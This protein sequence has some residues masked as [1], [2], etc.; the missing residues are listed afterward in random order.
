MAKQEADPNKPI[1]VT[2]TY[3]A[4]PVTVHFVDTDENADKDSDAVK[5]ELGK[6]IQLS[7]TYG[8]EVDLNNVKLPANFVID[9]TLPSVQYGKTDSVTINLKH[10]INDVKAENAEDATRT[11]VI[12]KYDGN[13][14]L[15]STQTVVQQIAFYKHDY[16][17]AVTGKTKSSK[18]IFDDK[19]SPALSHNVIDGKATNDPSYTLKDGKYYFAK[20]KLD[21][22]AG[23]K[24]EEKKINPNMMMI[25][26]FALPTTL[27][28]PNTSQT[29]TNKKPD[30]SS[31]SV[32]DKANNSHDLHDDSKKQNDQ[33][34]TSNKENDHTIN[35][36]AQAVDPTVEP[37][38]NNVASQNNSTTS[39]QTQQS[40]TNDAEQPENISNA[41]RVVNDQTDDDNFVDPSHKENNANKG[42]NGS[43]NRSKPGSGKIIHVNSK[44]P[45]N[46]LNEPVKGQTVVTHPVQSSVI[47]NSKS[48]AKQ[49]PQTNEADGFNYT[50]L[51]LLLGLDVAMVAAVGA[52]KKRKKY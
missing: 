9:D 27:T 43:S 52:E 30:T 26:L 50:A 49:L 36:S 35:V 24:A 32:T 31:S 23:Y 42:S 39:A 33:Q 12:N 21:V 19:S 3:I 48:D 44:T 10:H 6:T 16:V 46:G 47:N 34:I 1:N 45:Q 25:S 28:D 17:D 37:E 51:S 11:I 22:P 8:S 38:K 4:A 18:Y 20:Y 7:G 14:N 13:G 41:N 5:Q 29:D 40:S 2:V 15:T